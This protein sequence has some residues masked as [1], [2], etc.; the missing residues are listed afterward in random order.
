MRVS[1]F[2]KR[3]LLLSIEVGDLSADDIVVV[4]K[5][6]LSTASMSG[7]G[8]DLLVG[9]MHKSSKTY[10]EAYE[11]AEAVHT[12]TFGHRKY[13]GYD[14]YWISRHNRLKKG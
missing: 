4:S 13:A 8:F 5:E 14:S 9:R 7:G 6:V 11:K 1:I 3:K 2:N 12:L 10:I